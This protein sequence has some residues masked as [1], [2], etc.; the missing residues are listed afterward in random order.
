MFRFILP[1]ALALLPRYAEAQVDA[2]PPQTDLGNAALDTSSLW[3]GFWLDGG[4]GLSGIGPAY[5]GAANVLLRRWV[6][7]LGLSST[8]NRNAKLVDVTNEWEALQDYHLMVSYLLTSPTQRTQLCLGAGGGFIEYTEHLQ[9]SASGSL[10]A[11]VAYT[12]RTST[13]FNV[14]IR[15]VAHFFANSPLGLY[16]AFSAHM[17]T[18]RSMAGVTVGIRLLPITR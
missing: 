18:V 12:D 5:E 17:N 4:V 6:F 10:F 11:P 16:V 14:P 8:G 15:F 1:L 13:A 2:P 7:T 3:A 9:T